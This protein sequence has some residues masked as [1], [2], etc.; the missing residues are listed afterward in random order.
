M[1]ELLEIQFGQLDFSCHE[2]PYLEIF[3]FHQ[4][5]FLIKQVYFEQIQEQFP[6]IQ[7]FT[8]NDLLTV[9]DFKT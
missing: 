2:Q 7:F 6:F 1:F 5:L 8:N 3:C 4:G 9:V